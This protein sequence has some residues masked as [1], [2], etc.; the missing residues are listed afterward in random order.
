MKV[1]GTGTLDPFERLPMTTQGVSRW[2][3]APDEARASQGSG[4]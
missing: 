4:W 1:T 3:S 2:P